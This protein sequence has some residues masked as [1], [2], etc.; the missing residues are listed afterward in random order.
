MP[1][2]DVSSDDELGT[3]S[4]ELEEQEDSDKDSEN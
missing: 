1:R 4:L 3:W 2:D